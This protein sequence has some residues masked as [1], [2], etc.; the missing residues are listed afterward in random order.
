M[1]KE[2]DVR[3]ASIAVNG[4]AIADLDS[5]GFDQSK[6]HELQRTIDEESIWVKGTG[7]FTG[8]VVMKATSPS[9]GAVE[10]L[11][12]NDEI[13]DISV[14]YARSGTSDEGRSSSS[15]EDCMFLDFGP[16]DYELDDMPTVEGSWEADRANHH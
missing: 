2:Y 14:S 11:F 10:A 3:E 4:S 8:T 15:F 5:F 13:F 1:V 7:E 9:I 12:Q 6:A 16:S